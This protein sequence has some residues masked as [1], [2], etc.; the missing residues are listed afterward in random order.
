MVKRFM[1]HPATQRIGG[2]SVGWLL[3]FCVVLGWYKADF[4]TIVKDVTQIKADVL[5]M[6][7]DMVKIQ[8]QLEKEF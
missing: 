4:S 5:V 8:T 1:W 2:I 3:A 7:L 6:K